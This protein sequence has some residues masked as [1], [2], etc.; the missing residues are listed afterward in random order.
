[1]NELDVSDRNTIEEFHILTWILQKAG[2]YYR[3]ASY[4]QK[5]E[6]TEVLFSNITVDN[7]K[8]LAFEA[9]PW[10]D[11]LFSTHFSLS[12]DNFILL[13]SYMDDLY[14]KRFLIGHIYNML[15]RSE[16]WQKI[17]IH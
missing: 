11:M 2:E 3:N 13:N 7:K 1:M 15:I 9:N 14:Q 8:R 17:V 16:K 10:L 6:I 5:R 12:G 4:V